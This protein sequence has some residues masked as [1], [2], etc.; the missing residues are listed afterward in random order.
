[1]VTP[2]KK[3]NLEAIHTFYVGD[4]RSGHGCLAGTRPR[5]VTERFQQHGAADVQPET[6]GAGFDPSGNSSIQA[7]QGVPL[8]SFPEGDLSPGNQNYG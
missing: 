1:M 6:M 5:R 7:G 3:F 8:Q 2:E 4:R